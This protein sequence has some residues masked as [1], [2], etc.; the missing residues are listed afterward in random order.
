MELLRTMA[1]FFI[2][3]FHFFCHGLKMY[4]V[5]DLHVDASDA[6]SMFNYC[7]SWLVVIATSVAVDVYV[8]ITGYFIGC[9]NNTQVSVN[10]VVR[11]GG[12]KY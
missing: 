11:F 5:S 2:V 12:V 6:L 3:V 9:K 1:M 8:L 4:T 7:S 10:Q